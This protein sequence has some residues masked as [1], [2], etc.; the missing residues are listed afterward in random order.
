MPVYS[1]TSARDSTEAAR[2]LDGFGIELP[3][4]AVKWLDKLH[5]LRAE[6][7]VEAP[8]NAVAELF[9]DSAKPADIDKTLAYNATQNLRSGQHRHAQQ[10]VGRRC[11][12]ALLADQDRLH[13]ELAVHADAIIGRLHEAAGLDESI[14]DLTRARRTEEAHLLACA[15]SD[16]AELHDLYQVRNLY[17]TATGSKWLTGWYTCQI[18]SNP[19]DF[20]HIAENDGSRWG[21]QRATIR[22]GG[23]LR[24]VPFEVATA[25][26]TKHEPGIT[27]P[28]IDPRRTGATFAI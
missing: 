27:P 6:P 5:S 25:A 14:T 10:I 26:S 15:A 12:D 28:V 20:N 1:D 17:L 8:R 21:T 23:K 24:Y 16:A 19:W 2:A 22:A 3:P 18:W 11:L 9:A 7:P 4:E 13:A